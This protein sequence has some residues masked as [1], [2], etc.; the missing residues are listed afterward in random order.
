MKTRLFSLWLC[1]AFFLGFSANILKAQDFENQNKKSLHRNTQWYKMMY[2][3]SANVLEIEKSYNEYFKTNEFVESIET[4]EYKRWKRFM[5]NRFDAKGNIISPKSSKKDLQLIA[6]P[7][8]SLKSAS[9]QWSLIGP[10][11]IDM[12]APMQSSHPTQG[13]VRSIC[14]HPTNSSKVW[15][16]TVSSGIWYTADKG[17]NW[18]CVTM[19]NLVANVKGI[20]ISPSN[21]N[22]LYAATNSGVLKSTNGGTIWSHTNLDWQSDYPGGPE[23]HQM[24]V[25]PT[26]SNIAIIACSQGIYRTT[27][28][29]NNWTKEISNLAWDVEF[30]PTN[31]N[32]VYAVVGTS[33]SGYWSKWTYL[34]KSTD[35]GANWSKITNGLPS[36]KT[37]HELRRM[38]LSVS[39]ASPNKVWILA[40]GGKTVSGTKTEG[41][42]GFYVSTDSGTS[43]T[44]KGYGNDGPVAGTSSAPNMLDYSQD[45]TGSGGGQY[46]WDMDMVVSNVDSNYVM[47]GGIHVWHSSNG[48]DSWSNVQRSAVTGTRWFHWDCQCLEIVGNNIWIGTDGGISH[49]DN[50]CST[51]SNKSFGIVA[52]ELWGFDQA[53]KTDIMGVGMYHG[54]VFIRDDSIYDGWYVSSGAD[55]GNVIVNK[56][57]DRYLYAHPWGD[58][59]ITRS[60]NRMT[61]PVIV[62]LGAKLLAY[63]HPIEVFNH[64]YYNT[65]YTLDESKV[66]KTTDNAASWTTMKDFGSGNNP[67][68]IATSFSNNEVAYIIVNWNKIYKTTNGGTTWTEKTPASSLTQNVAFSNITIDGANPDIVWVS[69]KSKQ[70]TIKVIK[71][72]NGGNSWVD[73]SGP[74]NNLPSYAIN[75]IAHQIGTN[76]GVYIGTDAGVWYRNNSMSQWTMFSNGLPK[77]IQTWFVRLNYAKEKVRIGTLRGVWECDFYETSSSIANP[78]APSK[79][80]A[81]GVDVRFA[82]HSVILEGATYNWTFNGGTPSSS[83]SEFPTVKYD[84]EGSYDVSLTVTDSR[85]SVS[86][87]F[88]N[89][90]TVEYISQPLSQSAWNLV[91]VSSEETSGENGAATNAF[92]GDPATIWHT[93]WSAGND[94][95]PHEMIV[96]MG[97]EYQIEGFA[98][99]PRPGGGNGT[100]KDYELYIST[101]G[102]TWGSAVSSGS[103]ANNSTEKKETFTPKLGRYF[104]FKAISEVNGNRFASAGEINIYGQTPPPPDSPQIPSSQMTVVSYDSQETS[105]ENGAA[106]NA[107]DGNT[108]TIWHTKWSGS[109]DPYPHEI[110]I[111]LGGLY[112]VDAMSYTPRQSGEN[113]MISSYEIYLSAD[114]TNWGSAVKSGTWAKSS[115]EKKINFNKTRSKYM[116]LK[117]ISEVNGNAWASAAEIKAFGEAVTASQIPQSSISVH[118]VSS[119]ET[120]NENGQ[121]TNVLDGD[122]NTIWHTKWSSGND[123]YPHEIEFD[124]GSVKEVTAMEYLPRQ[125]SANGRIDEYELYVSTTASNWGDAVATGTWTNTTDVKKVEFTGKSGR[126]IKF[127]ATSEVNNNRF[128]SAAEMRF[129]AN[130]APLKNVQEQLNS[131]FEKF[132]NNMLDKST[133][134]AYGKTIHVLL[135]NSTDYS[136]EVFTTSGKRLVHQKMD[137]EEKE[138]QLTNVPNGIYII[139]IVSAEER[140]SKKIVIRQ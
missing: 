27:D 77:G 26:N 137:K 74:A 95:Y 52:Q 66:K 40:A 90:V 138:L 38:A 53:W 120:A 65:F 82:D 116:K 55:A 68:R 44:N 69:M 109:S 131:A 107:I 16:G 30:H 132:D 115:A 70:S 79:T 140:I 32:I 81:K 43:F 57:D 6:Q 91:S 94:N 84:Q 15:V 31:P 112:D 136:V 83:T 37:D 124:L 21:T 62:D 42:Y 89:M 47:V 33:T 25:H 28:G 76:G 59:K 18:S 1:C 11:K 111:N 73:Y 135:A 14:Q 101:D 125:N 103:W 126:Y 117:A 36:E 35:G 29:G 106:T 50:S 48:G 45:G 123:N 104:K 108:N 98:Y 39:A 34:W 96:D 121:A 110:V 10:K 19:N 122:N 67:Y 2:S 41:I 87:T 60:D 92:D 99:L 58:V 61:Q 128:A 127:K 93:R 23:P 9:S 71:S 22:I 114:G 13:V 24:K 49:S 119:Q 133:V 56:G 78:M 51:I 130:P 3:K 105:G 139:K 85:G 72:T 88:N 54:P 75:S 97:V 12:V 20:A 46:T 100:I 113:G 64:S 129:F 102:T 118:F 80:V 4:K 7:D 5:A 17:A 134:Y 86:K 63:I 8:V